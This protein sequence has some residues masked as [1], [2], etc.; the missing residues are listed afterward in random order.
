[1]DKF[2]FTKKGL[3]DSIVRQMAAKC[4][5]R[6]W[7]VEAPRGLDTKEVTMMIGAD[8]YH[9]SGRESVAAVIGTTNSTFSSYVSTSR[10]QQ[11]R[12]I[13]IMANIADMVLE[14]VERFVKINKRVPTT[15]IFYRDGVGKGQYEL[16]QE[17]EV[18]RI[19]EGLL[20]TF[21]EDKCPK[22]DFILVNK[23]INNRFYQDKQGFNS[24]ALVASN[25]DS[26]TIV[27]ENCTSDTHLDFFMVAQNVT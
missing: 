11:R 17:N 18:E 20:L 8:V 15:I 21:G 3:F 7:L 26:G 23:R 14:C 19:R 2:H 1:M 24:K 9:K 27:L 25:P 10:V 16:V 5:W 12:G 4:G 22:L 6:P 13:E